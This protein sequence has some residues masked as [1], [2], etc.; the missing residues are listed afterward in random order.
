[1]ACVLF[2]ACEGAPARSKP[3]RHQQ[4]VRGDSPI[5]APFAHE[6][7]QPAAD[8]R[9]YTLRIHLDADPVHLNPLISPTE[10]TLRITRDTVFETLIRY[11]PPPADEP[12]HPG[13]Y[14]PGLAHSWRVLPGGREIRLELA[15]GARFH[16]GTPVTA[17]DVQFSLEAA[18]R[19]GLGTALH[20]AVAAIAA[21]EVLSRR[22][23]RLRLVRPHAYTLRA[24][25]ELPVLPEH[26]YRG[27]LR[28]D[29]RAPIVGSGPYRM[30]SW[31]ERE[32]R[33]ARNDEYWGKKPAIRNIVFVR[34]PDAARAL[35]AAKAGELD[36]L[37]AVIPAH[38]PEH[39]AAPILAERFEPL[40]LRPAVF[41]YVSF[42]VRRA[43]FD[44][45]RVRR[46]LSLLLDRER[47]V[48]KGFRGLA[49]SV[50]GPVW[51]GGPMSGPASE[52][53]RA[54]ATGAAEL[55]AA[56]GWVDRD[57]DGVRERRGVALAATILA[58]EHKRPEREAVLTALR[59][60]GFRVDVRT[61][62]TA[63]LRYRLDR[64]AFNLAFMEWGGA[65]DRD[66]GPLL[67]SGGVENAGGFS[68]ER[69]D[70]L[71]AALNGAWDPAER[72]QLAAAL[73]ARLDETYPFVALPA[74]DPFG[75]ISRRVHGAVTWDNW[76]ALRDLYLDSQLR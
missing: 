51:P 38:Y 22:M 45:W 43:P 16:D 44:D 56:A 49:R 36:L 31:K 24:L 71:L 53:V 69:V 52:P 47:L 55:L 2:A 26:V 46:A 27:R 19:S 29:R 28:V 41:V 14:G 37:P 57:G 66:L 25:A 75:L 8:D 62:G 70:D 58:S 12:L 23:V 61:G 15:N 74:P 65:V 59:K 11:Q 7:R 9:R 21:V 39:A 68:D 5:A 32:I 13:S 3:W 18:R 48:K 6:R 34:E 54:D 60:G 72:S 76:L 42:N 64:G 20:E 17:S 30:E 50:S 1:L 4:D 40:R 73:A 67:R 63:V 33:L 35:V 10:W